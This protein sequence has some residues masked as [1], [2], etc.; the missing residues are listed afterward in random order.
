[1]SNLTEVS[2]DELVMRLQRSPEVAY[3][4]T[5]RLHELTLTYGAWFDGFSSHCIL[6]NKLRNSLERIMG[7]NVNCLCKYVV[8]SL[9]WP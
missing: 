2:M 3:T 4:A 8:E 1:M 9:P 5:S 6:L 7:V